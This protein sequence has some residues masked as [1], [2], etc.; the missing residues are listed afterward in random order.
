MKY[1]KRWL[2]SNNYILTKSV[3]SLLLVYANLY[4]LDEA[5]YP[6]RSFFTLKNLLLKF[7]EILLARDFDI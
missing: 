6:F 7:R 1:E 3:I 4:I 5:T 2:D